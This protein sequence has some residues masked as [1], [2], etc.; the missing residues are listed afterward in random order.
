MMKTWRNIVG[1]S[2][3]VFVAFTGVASGLPQKP[4]ELVEVSDEFSVNS[5]QQSLLIVCGIPEE[6]DPVS[7]G[8]P[9]ETTRPPVVTTPS[10]GQVVEVVVPA[11]V[12]EPATA[13]LIGLGLLGLIGMTIRRKR[14]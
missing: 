12:P 7:S 9:P 13:V 3:I 8:A 14:R 10:D 1:L 11:A 5:Q 4:T 6:F 2:L